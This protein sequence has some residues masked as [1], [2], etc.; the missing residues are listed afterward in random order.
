MR[1]WGSNLWQWIILNLGYV[2]PTRYIFKPTYAKVCMLEARRTKD[3]E[4]VQF[5]FHTRIILS[6]TR[7]D[8]NETKQMI[9]I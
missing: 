5:F 6:P 1:W 8:Y 4:W 2:N 7:Y 3:R 9:H